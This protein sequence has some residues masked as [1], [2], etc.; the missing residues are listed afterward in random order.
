[1]HPYGAGALFRLGRS[2]EADYRNRTQSLSSARRRSCETPPV[3]SE[4][5]SI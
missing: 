1:M 4:H 5:S 3:I 2:I